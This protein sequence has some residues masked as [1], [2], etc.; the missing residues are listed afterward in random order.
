MTVALPKCPEVR[1]GTRAPAPLALVPIWRPPAGQIDPFA[2]AAAGDTAAM[3]H[4]TTAA[5]GGRAF[6]GWRCTR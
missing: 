6:G 2:A 4:G 3:D 1:A 5:P